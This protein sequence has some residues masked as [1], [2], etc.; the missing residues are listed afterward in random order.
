M[1][2]RALIS[3]LKAFA[4]GALSVLGA[5][6][7]AGQHVDWKVA[8]GGGIGFVLKFF[9][10]SADLAVADKKAEAAK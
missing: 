6:L 1:T 7:S 5:Q 3:A 10:K 8:V 2:K 4:V 9:W